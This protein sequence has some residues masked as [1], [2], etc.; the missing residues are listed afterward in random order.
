M[1]DLIELAAEYG[2]KDPRV[3]TVINLITEFLNEKLLDGKSLSIK[4]KNYGLYL[5]YYTIFLKR[6]LF[7]MLYTNL[8][9]NREY[10]EKLYESVPNVSPSKLII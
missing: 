3:D 6:G 4:H 10:F 1:H 7:R 2:R 5:D 8:P 9:V